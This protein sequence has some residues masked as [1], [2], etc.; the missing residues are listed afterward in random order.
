MLFLK[1]NLESTNVKNMWNNNV[2]TYQVWIFER[3][4][5]TLPSICTQGFHLKAKDMYNKRR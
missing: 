4:Y 2:I 3:T 1:P 5:K